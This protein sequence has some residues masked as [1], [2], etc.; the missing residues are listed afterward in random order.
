MEELN[1]LVFNV[2]GF[3]LLLGGALFV[4]NR[5]QIKRATKK[6]GQ[7]AKILAIPQFEFAE[8]SPDDFPWLE[9]GFYDEMKI[10]FEKLG[11]RCFGDF[12]NLTVS[13]NF[14]HART[15]TRSFVSPDGTI[16]AGCYHFRCR[17]WMRILLALTRMKSSQHV[18]DFGT[19]FHGQIFLCTSNASGPQLLNSVPLII[20]QYLPADTPWHEL[21]RKHQEELHRLIESR[22]LEPVIIRTIEDDVASSNRMQAVKAEFRRSAGYISADEIRRLGGESSRGAAERVI[23]EMENQGRIK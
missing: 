13:R 18:C 19:E 22:G 6:I 21:L 2:F 9:R 20:T 12:E 11:F 14:P 5:W 4:L 23:R 3:L 10:W 15:F 17:G 7:H 16:S 8:V 1:Q